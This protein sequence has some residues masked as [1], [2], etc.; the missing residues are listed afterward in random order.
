MVQLSFTLSNGDKMPALGFGTWQSKDN[1]LEHA[2]DIAL[3]AGY[4]HIDTAYV[5]ENEHVIGKVLKK[6]FDS[7]KLKR[8]DLYIV[9]KL[10]PTGNRASCVQ[11]YLDKS[12]QNLGLDYVDMYLIHCPFAFVDGEDLHPIKDGKIILDK[13]TDHIATWKEM[14][15]QVD[16]GKTKAIGLSNFNISQIKR[17]YENARIKPSN[18]QIELHAYHQQKPLVDYCNKH[19]IVVTAYSPLG[20]PGLGKFLAQ[21]GTEMDL[22]N[23]LTNP[24]VEALA[25][26]YK[27]TPAQIVLR[28][29]IQKGLVVIPKSTNP[30]RLKNNLNIYDF[31]LEQD[32]MTLL[33]N[34]DQG[35]KG[36][37]INFTVF[38]G[39]EEHPEYPF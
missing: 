2:F 39:V 36:R 25:N 32:D 30:E 38:P 18:L 22:P 8:E 28:H 20:S 33:N 10:P 1:E 9:T 35:D 5:Y 26:K 13:Q 7:G 17:V 29:A 37:L 23:I 34:L 3:E 11:K 21:F 19:N 14:E 15:K 6:W 24:T 31:Q 16:A 27:K 12:L 4:R